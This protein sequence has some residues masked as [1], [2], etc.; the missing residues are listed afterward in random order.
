MTTWLHR[1]W[2]GSELYQWLLVLL[3]YVVVIGSVV[4]IMV[5]LGA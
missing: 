5:L 2:L 1:Q 3:L 4:W